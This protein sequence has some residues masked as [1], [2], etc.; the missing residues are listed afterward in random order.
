MM[1]LLKIFS[2]LVPL[3]CFC[4]CVQETYKGAEEPCDNVSFVLKDK[5]GSGVSTIS[6]IDY[7]EFFFYD[8]DGK[9][10]DRR[11]HIL[12]SQLDADSIVSF[13]L[14]PGKY[15]VVAWAKRIG[16]G[17][18]KP[19]EFSDIETLSTARLTNEIEKPGV[20]S[21]DPYANN[22]I[23]NQD[24][25][26]YAHPASP[27]YAYNPADEGKIFVEVPL[28]GEAPLQ[29]LT[30]R[31]ATIEVMVLLINTEVLA[32]SVKPL[33]VG[34]FDAANLEEENGGFPSQITF[35]NDI[36]EKDCPY[37]RYGQQS[38]ALS[39]DKTRYVARFNLPLFKDNNSL[40]IDIMD[41]L[42]TRI[43][44]RQFMEE[45]YLSVE[46]ENGETQIPIQVE[47]T[48]G[49]HAII[50]IASWVTADTIIPDI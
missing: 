1:K 12:K 34:V 41:G 2:V 22:Y 9:L 15:R 5:N 46:G 6:D 39:T 14:P 45:H 32:P 23:T 25:L 27:T 17:K 44:V 30:L 4:G 35:E 20:A 28:F 10:G 29:H 13:G 48:K 7:V 24:I 33:V 11:F 3:L 40:F 47:Y 26:Y 8:E 38:T 37:A 49:Q 43:D 16:F 31:P 19:T 42:G 18:D 50:T 36:P 21:A